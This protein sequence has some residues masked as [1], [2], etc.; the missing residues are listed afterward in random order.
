MMVHRWN[1]QH[2]Q[3]TYV[4][5]DTGETGFLDPLAFVRSERRWP[6]HGDMVKQY[7]TCIEDILKI[8]GLKNIE[9]YFDVWIFMTKRFQQRIFNPKTYFTSWMESISDNKMD[10]SFTGKTFRLE[11]QNGE[12]NTINP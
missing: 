6:L 10:Y 12:N 11:K 5:K 2:V 1:I 4:Q 9:L 8:Y 7:A 3:I